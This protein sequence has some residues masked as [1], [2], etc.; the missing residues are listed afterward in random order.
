[1]QGAAFPTP[2]SPDTPIY[3]YRMSHPTCPDELDKAIQLSWHFRMTTRA[4]LSSSCVCSLIYCFLF[5]SLLALSTLLDLEYTSSLISFASE[6]LIV[7]TPYFDAHGPTSTTQ[8]LLYQV[9]ISIK[10]TSNR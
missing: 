10:D 7:L 5:P 9:I 1:M 4:V 2:E 6:S 3:A 8:G